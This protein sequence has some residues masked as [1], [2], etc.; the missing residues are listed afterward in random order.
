MASSLTT[1]PP[2][3]SPGPSRRERAVRSLA[4]A[5][6]AALA[7][8]ALTQ[9]GSGVTDAA[10]PPQSASGGSPPLLLPWQDGQAWRTG[11]SGF[12]TVNDALDFFPPDIPL[13]GDLMC[14][15]DPGWV[16]AESALWVVAAAP[17]IV[18]QASD[19][20]VLIDHGN[21][22]VTGYYH[23]HSFQVMPG[24][25]VPPNWALGHPSTYGNC[26]TG[27]HVH[28]YA[29]GPNGK[30]LRDLNISGR[31][32]AG[33][34]INE[35]ISD[36]GNFPPGP[37]PTVTPAPT[38]TQA[39]VLKGDVN[40]DGVVN[41]VDGLL[42]LRSVANLPDAGAG[43]LPTAGDMDCNGV[44]DA[45]DALHILRYVAGLSSRLPF[46]CPAVAP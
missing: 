19:S 31:A 13:G 1:T 18:L 29:L 33:I 17:G 30:T 36:T 5:F 25:V 15:G 21:G 45:V 34:N 46:G 14:E 37:Q 39:P 16:P 10:S 23:V 3:R 27:P 20:L 6:V 24:D 43:C 40:C 7:T 9:G 42:V 32:A 38:P 41:S 22:W 4:L 26:T 28:F 12:H 8:L 11:I 2:E 35:V 44:V